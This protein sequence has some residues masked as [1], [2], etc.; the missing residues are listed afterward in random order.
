VISQPFSSILP[1]SDELRCMLPS[2]DELPCSDDTPVDNEE[3]NLQP[4]LLLFLLHSIW[5]ERNDWFFAV[6]MALYHTTGYSPR[7]PV[8]PDAF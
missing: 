5:A 7:V 1:S 2:T 8:V 4:N 3:Q 6:D